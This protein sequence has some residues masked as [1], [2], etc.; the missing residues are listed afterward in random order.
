MPQHSILL[1]R[2]DLPGNA[3]RYLHFC[4]DVRRDLYGLVSQPQRGDQTREGERRKPRDE[5]VGE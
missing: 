2:G 5:L 1:T 3:A 4:E